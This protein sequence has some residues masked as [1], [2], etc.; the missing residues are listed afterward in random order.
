[1]ETKRLLEMREARDS[2]LELANRAMAAEAL[3]ARAAGAPMR[4][5]AAALGMNR[6]NAYHFL[7]RHASS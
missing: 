3:R 5:V 4:E 7:E 1:M 2:A 6:P